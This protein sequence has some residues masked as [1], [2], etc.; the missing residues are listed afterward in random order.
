MLTIS[1]GDRGE[2]VNT[3]GCGPDISWVRFPS[4]APY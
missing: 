3:S 4:V 1:Y 2:V